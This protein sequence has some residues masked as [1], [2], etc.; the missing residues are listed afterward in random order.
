MLE[1]LRNPANWD[2][3]RKAA[4]LDFH[5]LVLVHFVISFFTFHL[6]SL[7]HSAFFI[8]DLFK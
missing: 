6:N 2:N 7:Q 4:V 1:P 8:R 5:F 3:F